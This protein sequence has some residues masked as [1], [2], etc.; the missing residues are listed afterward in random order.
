MYLWLEN[1]YY[2]PKKVHQ[3]VRD[4]AVAYPGKIWLEILKLGNLQKK[5]LGF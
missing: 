5:W 4:T 1:Q 2:M 3:G